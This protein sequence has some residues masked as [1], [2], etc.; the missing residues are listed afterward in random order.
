[1]DVDPKKGWKRR[2]GILSEE[3]ILALARHYSGRG[4]ARF[5]LYESTVFTWYPELRWA[6]REAGW[7]YDPHT[8][9][10]R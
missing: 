8:S 5:G 7:I 9:P 4:V 1:M 6:V 3:A 10:K 2:E